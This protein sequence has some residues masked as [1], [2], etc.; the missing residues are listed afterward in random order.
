MTSERTRCGQLPT[1]LT[2]GKRRVFQDISFHKEIHIFSLRSSFLR[3]K[4]REEA[5]REKDTA[6]EIRNFS[7]NKIL[8]FRKKF[9]VTAFQLILWVL[10]SALVPPLT[11]PRV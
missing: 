8:L 6:S 7:R 4:R 9:M 5:S 11:L 1:L 2:H 3:Q 10:P